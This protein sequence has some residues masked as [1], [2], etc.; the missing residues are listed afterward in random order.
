MKPTE[1]IPR[2]IMFFT[3]FAITFNLS[4]FVPPLESKRHNNPV[5]GLSLYLFL[6]VIHLSEDISDNQHYQTDDAYI[7]Y[8]ND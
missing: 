4:D 1:T 8:Q 3:K 6:N 5:F 7:A 2:L